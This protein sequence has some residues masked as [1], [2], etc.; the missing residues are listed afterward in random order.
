MTKRPKRAVF[1]GRSLSVPADS[2][3]FLLTDRDYVI[4]DVS[5]GEHPSLRAG[6]IYY[7]REDRLQFRL[8]LAWDLCH[9]ETPNYYV[10]PP[11]EWHERGWIILPL[12][13]LDA[14]VKFMLRP[15]RPE[16]YPLKPVG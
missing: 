5:R 1:V 12:E 13:S 6:W 3:A 15:P 9:V 10:V 7:P 4:A 8:S 14:L 16:L 2:V 11:A